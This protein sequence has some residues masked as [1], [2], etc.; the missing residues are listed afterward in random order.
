[1]GRVGRSVAEIH[2]LAG[3]AGLAGYPGFIGG[4]GDGFNWWASA[5]HLVVIGLAFS[6]IREIVR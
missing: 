5:W 2:L 6:H 4:S 3:K 1:M